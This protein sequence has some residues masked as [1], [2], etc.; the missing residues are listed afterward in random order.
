MT[1]LLLL[2]FCTGNDVTD[3]KARCVD[4]TFNDQQSQHFLL[5]GIKNKYSFNYF[6]PI[7]PALFQLNPYWTLL[8]NQSLFD[9]G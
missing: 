3:F 1:M 8:N 7:K 9:K 2:L 5:S 4:D 6:V